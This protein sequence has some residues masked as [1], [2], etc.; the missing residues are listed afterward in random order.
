MTAM[1]PWVDIV[2]W[3]T[4]GQRS[5]VVMYKVHGLPANNIA[6][7][8]KEISAQTCMHKCGRVK[9]VKLRANIAYADF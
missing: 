2:Q 1:R 9:G 6:T 4:S 5:D 7:T 8:T 3:Q